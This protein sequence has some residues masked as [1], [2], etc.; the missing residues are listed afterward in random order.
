MRILG[1]EFTQVRPFTYSLDLPGDEK[2]QVVKC[3]HH[4]QADVGTAFGYGPTAED[5]VRELLVTAGEELSEHQRMSMHRDALERAMV[6][7]LNALEDL[8]KKHS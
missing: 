3:L 8:C 5:A 6:R 2:L 4:W 1:R 7:N